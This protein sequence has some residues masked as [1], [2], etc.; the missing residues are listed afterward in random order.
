MVAAP[1][2]ATAAY[3]ALITALAKASGIVFLLFPELGALSGGRQA[4]TRLGPSLT[5]PAIDWLSLQIRHIMPELQGYRSWVQRLQAPALRRQ[6]ELFPAVALL[7]PRQ[8]G[9]TS[10]AL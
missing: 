1:V 5:S 2:L 10:L 6:L 3:L 8:V 7:G 4:G 9:K